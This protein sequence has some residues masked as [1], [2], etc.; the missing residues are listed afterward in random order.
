MDRL[1][2]R[3]WPFLLKITKIINLE[4]RCLTDATILCIW[5]QST[6]LSASASPDRFRPKLMDVEIESVLGCQLVE[7]S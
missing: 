7:S 6:Y 3:V 1:R 4:P 5:W 2:I